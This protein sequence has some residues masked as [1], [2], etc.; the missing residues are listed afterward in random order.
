MQHT[1]SIAPHHTP[2][3]TCTH[4]TQHTHVQAPQ[5]HPHSVHT[6]HTH[7][8]RQ[9]FI[10][11]KQAAPPRETRR[12]RSKP[13]TS[14]LLCCLRG[15]DES[16]CSHQMQ[17]LVDNMVWCRLLPARQT[18]PLAYNSSTLLH[19]PASPNDSSNANQT[20]RSSC[21]KHCRR[22]GKLMPATDT[23]A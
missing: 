13:P 12:V 23:S 18:A 4:P 9:I 8:G 15:R 19:P 16:T 1:C 2:T 3:M 22:A 17:R 6:P 21:S 7:L 20:C 5:T 11:L 14:A 10:F